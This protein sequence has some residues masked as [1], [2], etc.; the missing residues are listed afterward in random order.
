MSRND[1]LWALAIGAVW[2]LA[3]NDLLSPRLPPDNVAVL[4]LPNAVLAVA[5]LRRIGQLRSIA[6]FAAAA[7]AGAAVTGAL[8]SGDTAWSWV[9][10]GFANV[11]EAWVLAALAHRFGGAP[12][13]FHRPRNVAL[14]AAA[15]LAASSLS[16]GLAWLASE[17]GAASISFRNAPNAAAHWVFGDACAHFT[18]G[19]LLVSAT[20]PEARREVAQARRQ[21]RRLPS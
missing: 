10:L 6:L 9:L 12:F 14:W 15:A 3:G 5:I 11:A 8:R 18:L 16:M 1:G 2:V 20:G 13:H 21:W 4:W 7:L 19:A 17:M